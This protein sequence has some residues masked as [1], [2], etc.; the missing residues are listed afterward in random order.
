MGRLIRAFAFP[1]GV[2]LAWEAYAQLRGIP[3]E[4]L[5]YPSAILASGWPALTDGT[6][7][8]ATYQTFS[9]ALVGLAVGVLIGILVGVPLGLLPAAEAVV[10]PTLEALRP[11]PA[12]ALLP[13][14]LLIFGFGL[15]MEAAIV[16]IGCLWPVLLVTISAVRNIDARLL[17]IGRLLQLSPLLRIV[18]IVLPATG[19]RICIGIRIAAGVSL[20]LAITVEIALNPN[21]LGYAMVT[22]SQGFDPALLWAELLW[23]GLVGWGFNR[24]L[25]TGER[26]WV[27]R[28]AG[29]AG[30]D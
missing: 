7:L 12:I 18:R 3:Y 15:R 9:A 30:H 19:A 22:A 10:G 1:A 24:L 21:G 25:V 29:G 8:L 14:A 27:L 20:A 16:A 13:L 28:Y 26:R 23:V 2:V 11:I 4:T 6:L 17:E 5:S